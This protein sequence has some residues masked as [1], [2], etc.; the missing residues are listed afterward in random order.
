MAMR[1]G[2]QGALA[3]CRI[4]ITSSRRGDELAALLERRGAR[5]EA[6]P[7]LA[8]TPCPDD[9]ALRALTARCIE[10]PPEMLVATTGLGMSGW[11][12][13]AAEWGR[14]HDL[15]A[16]L[17][18]AEI[19]VRGPRAV[20]ALRAAGLR[21]TWA[22]DSEALEDVLAHLRG[23]QLHGRRIVVQ[24]H[25]SSGSGLTST[26]RS[27][28]G[29]VSVATVHRFT[30][31]S[32]RE[33]LRRLV[34]LVADRQLDA[35]T[36]TSAPAARVLL[37]VAADTGRH[38][39]FVTALRR[40]VV[41]ACI[42]PV[43]AEAFEAWGIPAVRPRRARLAELVTCLEDAVAVRRQGTRLVVADRE[44]VLRGEQVLVDG[45]E[46]RLTP[47]PRAMLGAL[48][49]RPGHVLSRAEL[50]GLLPGDG[51]RT[52]HAVEATVARLRRAIGPA[53]V[54]TVTKRGYR[55]AVPL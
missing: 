25:G 12:E 8:I 2:V 13:A 52:E 49:R 44:L 18:R 14:R 29:H 46:V 43:T 20:A 55:L 40:D 39:D 54:R 16:A 47:G 10:R 51:L 19:F 35:L 38:G 37:E 22:S 21:E 23:R 42:G 34:R 4:G 24:E 28:G 50:L 15:V 6:A 17:R 3:G 27:Q 11:L 41:T 26:L 33:P 32:D 45:V 53:M 9:A 1:A 31:V 36:F 48:A 30:T 5:V 7:A